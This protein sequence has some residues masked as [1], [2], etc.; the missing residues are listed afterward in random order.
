MGGSSSIGEAPGAP[1]TV[2]VLAVSP[3]GWT[4]DEGALHAALRDLVPDMDTVSSYVIPYA[5]LPRR[6]SRYAQRYPRWGDVAGQTPAALLQLP[7]LG[8]A[9]VEALIAAAADAVRITREVQQAGPV[10]PG[11]AI[12]RLMGQLS[13]Y[14]QVILSGRVWALHPLPLQ[15]V[16]ERLGVNAASVQRNLPR[17]LARVRELLAEPAHREIPA[18]AEAL[19]R[20]LGPFAPLDVLDIE[21]CRRGIDPGSHT[22]QLLL[23]I[24]GPYA[25]RGA[26]I[27]H[28]AHGGHH[29]ISA[30]LDEVLAQHSAPT[31]QMLVDSLTAQ[32]MSVGLALRYLRELTQLRCFGDVWVQ[33]SDTGVG[34]KAEAMLHVLGVPVTI[35]TLEQALRV[36]GAT[37][38]SSVSRAIST[39]H[40]IVR[41][42]RHNWGLRVWGLPEYTGLPAAIGQ[43]IDAAGGRARTD[44]IIRDILAAFPDVADGSIRAYLGTLAFVVEKGVARRR[45]EADAWPPVPPMHAYR[46]GYLNG[47]NEIRVVVPVTNDLLRGSGQ[48]ISPPVAHAVGVTPGQ[49]RTFTGAHGQLTLYWNLASTTD[50]N[51]GS[52]RLLADAVDATAGDDLVLAL[53]PA[54]AS[55]DVTRARRDEPAPLRLRNI[56]GRT[57]TTPITTLAASL[58]CAPEQ[59]CEI[60]RGRGEQEIAALVAEAAG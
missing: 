23:H 45:T 17:A 48:P 30:A 16:A 27:E 35:E 55:L 18:H 58:E 26:W 15:T 56:L 22:A 21:F 28:T 50:A 14:D 1:N 8:E 13:D 59:V 53:R 5:R 4:R 39:D 29:A 36:A 60:L 11:P 25:L 2:G 57:T 47:R 6:L 42:S 9:S 41:T 20:A 37:N 7:K 54:D 52:L 3:T 46:G 33:W 10:G 51:I 12:T 32:G 44:Y 38:V 40:R 43:R 49:R 19:R 34:N 31:T 24:A